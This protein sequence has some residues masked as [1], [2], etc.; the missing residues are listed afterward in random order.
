MM[1][2]ECSFREVLMYT[3]VMRMVGNRTQN[4]PPSDKNTQSKFPS[5]IF[6]II[7]PRSY[8][9]I[10]VFIEGIFEVVDHGGRG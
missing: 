4:L 9:S 8:P 5:S 1:D 7:V 6:R 2:S 3:F 10:C